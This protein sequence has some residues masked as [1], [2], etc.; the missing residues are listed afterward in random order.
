MPHST[1]GGRVTAGDSKEDC[2]TLGFPGG[3]MSQSVING[4]SSSTGITYNCVSLFDNPMPAWAD[5]EDPWMFRTIGDGWDAWL[6]ANPE[7]EV[8]MGQDLVPQ[9]VSGH[10]DPLAWE[11]SCAKGDYDE[12]A[13]T[14]ARNL[15]AHGAGDIVIRLGPEANGSWEADYVGTTSAG[16]SD[17]AKCYANEVTAMRAVPGTHFLFVWNPNVCSAYTPLSKWYPGNAYVDIIGADAYDTDCRTQKTVSQEGWQSYST[18]SSSSGAEN[19][20]FP[21]LANIEAFATAHEKPMSFPEWGLPTG[22]DDPAYVTGMARMFNSSDFS[23]QTYFDTNG[24]GI[25]RLGSS[26][27]QATRAYARAFR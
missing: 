12:H 18:D 20:D 11:E 17:W 21:S 3:A 15:V 24:D 4:A 22:N 23:F 8:I 26:V 10:T 7:H 9:T 27:P 25:A 13:R 19:P 14:L 16:M 6:A 5:W 2:I 1:P